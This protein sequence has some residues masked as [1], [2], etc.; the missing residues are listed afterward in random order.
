MTT[1][2]ATNNTAGAQHLMYY[3]VTNVVP[4]QEGAGQFDGQQNV[5]FVPQQGGYG[6]PEQDASALGAVPGVHMGNMPNMI[7]NSQQ[8]PHNMV[9]MPMLPGTQQAATTS[10]APPEGGVQPPGPWNSSQASVVQDPVDPQAAQSQPGALAR[11][12]TERSKALKIINP[13]THEEV[14]SGKDG[15]GTDGQ[16]NNPGGQGD[17]DGGHEPGQGIQPGPPMRDAMPQQGPSFQSGVPGGT[18][19]AVPPQPAGQGPAAAPV[20]SQGT[21]APAGCQSPQ[22]A[23]TGPGGRR[24]GLKNQKLLKPGEKPRAES[25]SPVPPS[26]APGASSTVGSPGEQLTAPSGSPD[27]ALSGSMPLSGMVKS[28]GS[29]KDSGSGSVAPSPESAVRKPGGDDSGSNVMSSSPGGGVEGSRRND[30]VS[31]WQPRPGPPGNQG[32]GSSVSTIK[33]LN[34]EP[35]RSNPAPFKR[36]PPRTA[37]A[38]QETQIPP[39]GSN[40]QP[41]GQESQRQSQQASPK[42]PV[43]SPQQPQKQPPQ[44]QQQPQHQI[45]PPTAAAAA[46]PNSNIG[47]S[48]ANQAAQAVQAQ[49][50]Q[51]AQAQMSMSHMGLQQMPMGQMGMGMNMQQMQMGQHGQMMMQAQMPHMMH[52]VPVGPSMA[53]VKSKGLKLKNKALHR[54]ENADG[55]PR[56][57]DDRRDSS[58]EEVVPSPIPPTTMPEVTR[59]RENPLRPNDCVFDRTL[60]LR[61]WRSHRHELHAAVQGLVTGP[62]LGDKGG[63]APPSGTP[64]EKRRRPGRDVHEP[65]DR[66]VFGT[67]MKSGKKK[68]PVLK[69]SE[70]GYRV[71]EPTKRDEEIERKVRSLLNKICPENLKA[72]VERLAHIELHKSEELEFVIRIIFGKALCEPHYCETYADM[73]YALKNKY[74]EFPPESEGEKAQTFTRVLLNTCQ[75]EFESLP[76]TF[77]PSDEERARLPAD[78]LRMEMKRRKDKMLANM[79]FIGNLFLRQLLAVKV[80]GQVV[81]DLIGVKENNPEEHM[82]ECVVELLQAIGYTLDTTPHGKDLMQQFASRL[83]ELKTSAASDSKAVYS[84][85]VQ[86]LIQDLLDLRS[87]DWKKKLFK[88]QA[89]TKEEVRKDA[90]AEA[91]NTSKKG[92][93]AMFNTTIAGARPTYLENAIGTRGMGHQG[94]ANRSKRTGEIEWNEAYVKRIAQYYVEDK[95]SDELIESWQKAAPNSKQAQQGLTWLL[96]GG[97]NDSSKEAQIAEVVV[98]LMARRVVSWAHFTEAMHPFLEGLED[99]RIDVPHC[100]HFFHSLFA[101]LIARYGREFSAECLK[102][103]EP[104]DGKGSD[105]TWKLLVGALK[106]AKQLGGPDASRKALDCQDF[107]ALACK[108]KRCSQPDLKRHLHDEGCV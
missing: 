108:A 83:I 38:P 71:Q 60:M 30:A 57:E 44:N 76:T 9:V 87:Q 27:G 53:P 77:E 99:M 41:S 17:V 33:A 66:N 24:K 75:N 19:S 23:T 104:A 106:K 20:T 86:F 62:R 46:A 79:R 15:L 103:L 29:A 26:T 89:K 93:D 12:T 100:D 95:N 40:Q 37:P 39:S 90:I 49:A 88:E 74:P 7:G 36:G 35:M 51:A 21:P 2:M 64:I 4:G 8:V 81:H 18:G 82:I 63:N 101:R 107:V 91:K 67:D 13:H 22:P 102:P 32:G 78:E 45:P 1:A 58:K 98:E 94:A 34:L 52:Q 48:Q 72:I 68:D 105:F 92:T 61:I 10:E 6:Y 42:V 70:K 28:P 97:F 59:Q 84:K 5:Q 54:P 11:T 43:A 55:E 69:V 85:R 47:P 50:A 31:A 80:I 25:A 14:K 96:H 3:Y 16:P 65:P 73:V 56:I